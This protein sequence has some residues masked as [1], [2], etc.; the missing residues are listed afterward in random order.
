VLVADHA[1]PLLRRGVPACSIFAPF[2]PVSHQRNKTAA[3]PDNQKIQRCEVFHES[4]MRPS[5]RAFNGTKGSFQIG[6]TP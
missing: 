5:V 1:P 2:A 6:K 4:I 3:K